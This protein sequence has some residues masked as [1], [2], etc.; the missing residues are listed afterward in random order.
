MLHMKYRTRIQYTEI[1][2]ALMWDRW[3]QGESLHAIARL[4]DRHHST[5]GG[6]L[7]RTGGIRPPQRRRSSLVL[8]LILPSKS[9]GKDVCKEKQGVTLLRLSTICMSYHSALVKARSNNSLE[10]RGI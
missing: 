7:S 2:K 9:M 4:F 10:R 8:A 5:V 6:V 3:R 1:D